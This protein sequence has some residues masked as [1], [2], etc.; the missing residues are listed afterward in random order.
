MTEFL[1]LR[2][3]D[4]ARALLA[5]FPPVGVEQV[6]AAEADGRVAAEDI[7]AP[8]DHPPWPRATRDGYAVRALDT[9]GASDAVPA[10]LRLVGSVPM[11]GVLD[12]RL[13]PGQAAAIATGGVLPDGTDAVVM[14]EYT[15]A[16][17][18]GEVEIRRGVA[19]GENRSAP[20]DDLHAGEILVAAGRRLRPAD[21]GVLA[22]V[23][24]TA[25]SA[26]RR[27]RLGILSTGDEVVAAGGTPRPGQVRDVNG[28][29]LAAKARRAGAE[30]ISGGIVGDDAVALAAALAGLLARCDAILLSGGSS[31]GVRDLS[32]RVLTDAGATILAHGISVRPGKPTILAR[33]GDRPVF[34]MPGVPVSAA[35]IFDVFVRPLLWRRGGELAREPW[36]ARRR[37]RLARRTASAPGREDY[38]RVRLAERDGVTWAAPL[39][40]G[41]ASLST[42]LRADG[43]VVVPAASEGLSAG[44]EVE[45]LLLEV[46]GG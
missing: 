1:L 4:E 5:D 24:V 16:G 14:V 15:E 46:P 27:P 19:A 39:L 36:P 2:T 23:G 29:L 41:S 26:R 30:V 9:H 43:L 22:A 42:A 32:A 33:V 13:E 6:P 20:G 25:V 38:L 11:G 12:L 28:P 7:R 17:A 44:D 10:F 40:G 21:L 3:A 34:G 18:A 8:E 45:V 35:V 37:A 31:V